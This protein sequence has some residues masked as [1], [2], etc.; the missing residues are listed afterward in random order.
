[1]RALGL[2]RSRYMGLRKTH[3]GHVAIATAVNLI[4][5]MSWLRGEVPEQTR[6]SPFTRLMKPAV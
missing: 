1:V 4:Q 2:R 6:A 5:L 3:L